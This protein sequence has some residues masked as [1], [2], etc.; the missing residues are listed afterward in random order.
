V[1]E[2]VTIAEVSPCASYTFPLPLSTHLTI[3]VEAVVLAPYPPTGV[4]LS[5]R[6]FA[7]ADVM[8][9]VEVEFA[10]ALPLPVPVEGAGMR[11][12]GVNELS[13]ASV[14]GVVVVVE[15]RRIMMNT[16]TPT[17]MKMMTPAMIYGVI[18]D[19]CGGMGVIL[20]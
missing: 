17:M 20:L 19:F 15:P 10:K 8:P 13:V 3:V 16:P 5:R 1:L 14:V 9:W 11:P 4:L 18:E 6:S 2:R 7:T 12:N